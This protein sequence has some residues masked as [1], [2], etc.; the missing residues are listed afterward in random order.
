[1][2]LRR[3]TTSV[4]LLDELQ[5]VFTELGFAPR[6]AALARRRIVRGANMVEPGASRHGVG[7]DANNTPILRAALE[8]G[9]DFL[10]TNDRHLLDLNPYEGLRIISMPEYFGLLQSEGLVRPDA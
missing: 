2:R 10:V 3:M 1:M 5:R 4:Y 6:L 7:G 9:A 8:A